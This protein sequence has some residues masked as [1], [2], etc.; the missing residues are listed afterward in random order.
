MGEGFLTRYDKQG[1]DV[2]GRW[3]RRISL[4]M[5]EKGG[6]EKRR[7]EEGGSSDTSSNL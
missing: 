3:R 1:G 4:I 2:G 5:L 6:R 7:G